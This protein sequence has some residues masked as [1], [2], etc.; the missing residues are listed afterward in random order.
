[1]V[2]SFTKLYA[3]ILVNVVRRAKRSFAVEGGG[4]LEPSVQEVQCWK[5]ATFLLSS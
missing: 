5:R 3:I 2:T 1:M 4:S